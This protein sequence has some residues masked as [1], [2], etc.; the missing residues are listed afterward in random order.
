VSNFDVER[1]AS[2][3]FG[4]CELGDRR[5]TERLIQV[6]Q[7][8]A[9]NP[10]VSLPHQM[11][12]WGDLKAAYRLFDN[13]GV[14]LEAIATPHWRKTRQQP[15]GRYLVIGDTT[16]LD[17][18]GSRT[19]QGVGHTGNGL[20]RGFLLHTGLMVHAKTQAVL[21]VAG[22]T[23]HYRQQVKKG[24]KKKKE[25]ASQRMKRPRESEVWGRVIDAIGSPPPDVEW[26]HVFDRGADSFEVYCHLR[27]N[28]SDWVIRA[29][30]KNREVLNEQ[31]QKQ[32]VSEILERLPVVGTYRLQVRAR[33]KQ[34]AR[35]AQLEV[36]IGSIRMPVPKYASP[37]VKGSGFDS[38]VMSVVWVREVNV[39]A[40]VKP[41]E[42]ILFTSLPVKNFEDAWQVIEYY[43]A[44]WLIDEYHKALKTGCGVTEREL[45]TAERLEALVGLLSVVAVRLLALKSMARTDAE[46]PA[47]TVV[48]ALWLTMLKAARKN[49]RR[50]YDLTVR[51]FYRELAKL[52]GFLGRKHDGEPG[53]I[54]IWR[55]W[56]KL[57]TLVH[58][59]K[60]LQ[61]M[62]K[63][64]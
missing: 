45:R 39:P 15:A 29:S 18:G 31:G 33:P 6:A 17:F 63:S 2:E 35:E 59:A 46:R 58:G 21:G 42:W 36:R 7:Q 50:V 25:S 37:Y 43:E 9:N 38:I 32:P 57:S 12:T 20:G 44:R 47:K 49:L 54:T 10:S 3:E 53:W 62:K 30:K 41:I 16:E 60:L 51:Q 22:Q 40:G 11:E 56:E 1:W 24:K 19:I 13:Q 55:G 4:S 27:Q 52:G 48:P 14:T 23:T 26:V 28:H 5:R 34:A 64:G 8:V 61:S